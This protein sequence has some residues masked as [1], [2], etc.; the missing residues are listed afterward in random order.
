MNPS[1]AQTWRRTK[2]VFQEAL[3]LASTERAELL[4]RIER[5]D[6]AVA[7]DV[8]AM[9]AAHD[10]SAGFL[11][12]PFLPAAD[13]RQI[14]VWIGAV[15]EGKYRIEERTGRG[16]MGA[17]YRATH[18]WTGRTVAVKIIAPEFMANPEFVER[19]K[20]EARAAGSLRHP[21]VVN[22][23]DFGLIDEK[24][25]KAAYL[26]MEFLDGATLAEA[27]RADST[28]PISTAV[29]VLE[30]LALAV[31][32]AHAHGILHRDIKP[33]NVWLSPDGRGGITVKVLDFGLAKLRE[34]QFPS[35]EPVQPCPASALAASTRVD[36]GF[37]SESNSLVRRSALEVQWP[38]EERE[39]DA[40]ISDRRQ[41]PREIDPR[42]VGYGLTRAGAVLGTPAYMSPEQWQARPLTPASD[43]YG[44]GVVVYEMLT[45]EP[46]FS[47]EPD[48]L[49]VKHTEMPVPSLRIKRPEVSRELDRVVATALSKSA[50]DRPVSARI[51]AA[52]VR[53]IAE[54]EPALVDRARESESS[55]N[56]MTTDAL[57][58]VMLA[59]GSLLV[60]FLVQPWTLTLAG[61]SILQFTLWMVPLA[62]F[63]ATIDV[64]AASRLGASGKVTGLGRLLAVS[65]SIL[66]PA[67]ILGVQVL[68]T[69][70][71]TARESVRRSSELVAPVP[72]FARAAFLRRLLG[73]L[74]TLLA[75]LVAFAAGSALTSARI[76]GNAIGFG[77]AFIATCLVSSFV[78]AREGA[79]RTRLFRLA[80]SLHDSAAAERFLR[81]E[82][83]SA[84]PFRQ[85]PSHTL[86][87][88]AALVAT[89]LLLG[90]VHV[91]FV[92][93]FGPGPTI[94]Q[95]SADLVPREE[96][97][98]TEYHLAFEAAGF[99]ATAV[100][101]R[102][103]V[104]S[105]RPRD[106]SSQRERLVQFQSL[107]G[108]G[109]WR[110]PTLNDEQ[111]A[112]VLGNK[113]AIDHLLR[114][115]LL[116]RSQ[117][118]IKPANAGPY[119]NFSFPAIPMIALTRL[120]TAR[121]RVLIEEGLASEGAAVY[122]AAYSASTRFSD[123]STGLA[124]FMYSLSCRRMVA[125][126]ILGWVGRAGVDPKLAKEV[127]VEM[128][129]LDTT[130]PAPVDVAAAGRIEVLRSIEEDESNPFVRL[131]DY[132]PGLRER[133]RRAYASRS[134]VIEARLEPYLQRWDVDGFESKAREL[135]RADAGEWP[136]SLADGALA[137]HLLMLPVL[138][139]PG[140]ASFAY[141]DRFLN[142]GARAMLIAEMY[143][144]LQGR[145]P[146]RIEDAAAVLDVSVPVDV[147]TG[148]AI[149]YRLID[150]VPVIRASEM[151]ISL[152]YG[153]PYVPNI[154]APWGD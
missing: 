29:D 133:V 11:S 107:A 105:S 120:A 9:L 1:N 6:I 77:M 32:E 111:R 137:T 46:P 19:F 57:R 73:G 39:D 69:T 101:D 41:T 31:D 125:W 80:S 15:L 140:I 38:S 25:N 129:R 86:A 130:I 52:T 108:F 67:A 94:P 40:A 97:A 43:I 76:Q 37:D 141:T 131:L 4:D 90:T 136:T 50:M 21:N 147:A 60:V 110:Q 118:S 144:S 93:P 62:V 81:A 7:R 99:E 138:P 33:S 58:A 85:R 116:S 142:A 124:G 13:T 55:A 96:N 5:E 104:I 154:N 18:L 68:T 45:G 34:G 98:W 115:A 3:A 122:V 64:A 74:L 106:T 91:L 78:E 109:D 30:Q 27:L 145:F 12:S 87:L 66:R 59:T 82:R 100:D 22:V 112:L 47:G 121:A 127:L 53:A 72:S 152:K 88:T 35:S 143:R 54:G 79:A 23:T 10:G 56:T 42:T 14:D 36:C 95:L 119:G 70:G 84:L 128:E 63:L 28:F 146:V 49:F 65:A 139:N 150:G 51:F 26:V 24:G 103:D 113:Q 89:S 102:T 8:R 83:P 75:G 71:I 135:Y 151:D 148:S 114:G 117:F 44:L 126:S 123:P 134:S 149:D 16:G 61:S 132:T 153:E 92:P 17:V 2:A 48:V 20:G